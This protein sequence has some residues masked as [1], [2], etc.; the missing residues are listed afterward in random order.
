MH[1]DDFWVKSYLWITCKFSALKQLLNGPE[2]DSDSILF[3]FIGEGLSSGQRPMHGKRSEVAESGMS[4]I[5]CREHLS[6]VEWFGD[7]G[8]ENVFERV[9]QGFEHHLLNLIAP[10]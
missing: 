7:L 8:T 6:F 3:S 9:V 2:D 10:D 1:Y 4:R 5:S